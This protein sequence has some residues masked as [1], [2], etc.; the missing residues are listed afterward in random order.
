METL[1]VAASPRNTNDRN[2]LAVQVS[3]NTSDAAS[4]N[5]AAPAIALVALG[6]NLSQGA[7]TP[8]TALALALEH[9][10]E[11]TGAKVTA[12]RL[13]RTPAYPAG[14]G[15]DFVN[16]A[17]ALPW[18]GSP[19]ALLAILHRIE[20]GLG[21]TRKTRWEARL[22]D[23][24]LIALG[25]QVH[26]DAATQT[27]WASLP[28]GQAAVETPDRLIL[29]HPRLTERAFVLIPLRDVA[30]DW[31]HPLTGQCVTA[32]CAALPDAMQAEVWPLNSPRADRPAQ[33][34]SFDQSGDT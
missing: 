22:M 14:A 25:A 30:P 33:P 19:E 15:P 20:E 1:A 18:S 24:D 3:S 11:A 17:A 7:R 21:R 9:L 13:F 31:V 27:H 29:P 26:P 8:A 5:A 32:M 10:S 12:S 34:L 28:P 23:L 6:A 4:V 16:A 2:S